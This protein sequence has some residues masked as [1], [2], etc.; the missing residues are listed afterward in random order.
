MPGTNS[1]LTPHE[2]G[3]VMRHTHQLQVQAN[4]NANVV[5]AAWEVRGLASSTPAVNAVSNA[6]VH[7]HVQQ[8]GGGTGSRTELFLVGSSDG[9]NWQ[10]ISSIS[11]A[12]SANEPAWC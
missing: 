7:F 1:A 11:R 10:A 9:V 5:G 4:I 8:T 12:L 2:S 3:R 6:A